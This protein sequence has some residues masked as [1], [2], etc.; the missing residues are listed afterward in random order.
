MATHSSNLACEIPW[1]EEPGRLQS[2]QSQRVGHDLATDTLEKKKKKLSWHIHISKTKSESTPQLPLVNIYWAHHLH[3]ILGEWWL[4]KLY[5]IEA[6]THGLLPI[7]VCTC[8][9][10]QLCPILCDPFDCSPPGSSIHGIFQPKILEWVAI[11]SSRGS[12]QPRD[13]TW[14]PCIGRWVLYHWATWEALPTLLHPQIT[15]QLVCAPLYYLY[16]YQSTEVPKFCHA[17]NETFRL[18]PVVP[19]WTQGGEKLPRPFICVL[20]KYFCW[21]HSQK[22]TAG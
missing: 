4:W 1:T 5:E 17:Y 21:W 12:S 19:D 7:P 22:Q 14:V 6:H 20:S 13:G 11:S 18:F 3:D 8:A 9:V 15:P 16:L 10:V 2:M